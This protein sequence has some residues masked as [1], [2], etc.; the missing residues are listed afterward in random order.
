M[1]LLKKT[2]DKSISKGKPII[3]YGAPTKIVL[4]LKLQMTYLNIYRSLQKKFMNLQKK[5]VN[6]I[7]INMT[8]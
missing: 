6:N 7:H 8:N 3:A 1:K 2:I 5:F 4:L